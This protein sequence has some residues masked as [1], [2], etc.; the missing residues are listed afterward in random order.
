M[1][2]VYRATVVNNFN[3]TNIVELVK[4]ECTFISIINYLLICNISYI[5]FSRNTVKRKNVKHVTFFVTHLFAA[6]GISRA[7]DTVLKWK[8][9]KILDTKLQSL[10]KRRFYNFIAGQQ[11]LLSYGGVICLSN[12]DPLSTLKST[13]NSQTR[14]RRVTSIHSSLC[15]LFTIDLANRISSQSQTLHICWRPE[16]S[17][18]TSTSEWRGN[19]IAKPCHS[20]GELAPH[21]M[22]VSRWL[23][24][25]PHRSH[26][27]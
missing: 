14:T 24:V 27:L 11:G 19:W 26:A 15:S 6:I 13:L 10:S 21:Q 23:K 20:V 1:R 2:T 16:D 9:V 5:L 3:I 18:A 12:S 7:F 4:R 8:L 25:F 17:F 22:H